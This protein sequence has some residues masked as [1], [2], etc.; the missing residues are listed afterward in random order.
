[1]AFEVANDEEIDRAKHIL[2][3]QGI[4]I[5]HEP[6]RGVEPGIGRLLRFN[7]PEGNTI[8][9][10]S[11]VSNHTGDYGDRPVKPLSLDH[12]T[13]FAG[14][15][16]KQQRFYETVLGMRVRDTVPGFL[17]FL[18][19]TAN[20]HS[21][22]FIALPRRGFHHIAFDYSGRAEMMDAIVHLGDAGF[23]R[24]DGP[25]RHGPGNMLYTYFEDPEKNLVELVTEIEQIEDPSHQPGEW[26]QQPALNLWRVGNRMGPP[27]GMGWMVHVLAFVSKRLKR[28]K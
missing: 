17:T 25:G 16:K 26:D 1:M 5:L 2:T 28:R 13:F 3:Q 12:V 24:V 15:V 10:V 23:K 8:E 4:P 20:H 11:D 21:L 22:G 27:P 7:D 14:D 18:T 9:L 6:E 19:C